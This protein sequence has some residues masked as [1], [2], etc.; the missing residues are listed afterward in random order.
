MPCLNADTSTPATMATPSTHDGTGAGR[1][2]FMTKPVT[3]SRV[4][5]AK[6]TP[7]MCLQMRWR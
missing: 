3:A 5:K 1:P 6:L 4:T 2:N 7:A